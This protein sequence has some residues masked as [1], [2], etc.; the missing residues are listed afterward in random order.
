MA[1]RIK[2]LK[3]GVPVSTADQPPL[4]YSYDRPG[5]FD[6][7]CGTFGLDDFQLPHPECPETF[8]C[9]VGPNNQPFASCI[10]AMNCHMFVGMT[11]G[12][13][14]RSN[15]ALFVHQMIPHHQNAVNMAKTL[16]ITDEIGC[17]DLTDDEDPYCVMEALLRDIVNTQVR[18][19]HE[20][21]C[22]VEFHIPLC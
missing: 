18:M 17:A 8:V 1:G 6:R 3:G 22:G 14:S 13:S 9:D 7:G 16:L 11:T 20:F 21:S 5:A 12:V 4:G 10:D 19:L 15:I 2:L